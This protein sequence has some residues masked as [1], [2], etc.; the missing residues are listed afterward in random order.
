MSK[1]KPPL[2]PHLLEFARDL[3]QRQTT[4]EDLLW[5]LL[6]N[7]RLFD[8]KFRRQHPVGAYVID[9]FAKP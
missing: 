9:F 1:L 2:P 7:R 5:D 8:V 3:R 4:A 6:R